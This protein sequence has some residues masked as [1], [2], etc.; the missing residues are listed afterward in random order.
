MSQELMITMAVVMIAAMVQSMTGFG[1]GLIV[2]GL[3]SL[4]CPIKSA[5]VLNVLPALMI[6]GLLIWRLRHHLRWE[7]L[8]P[9]AIA[10][11][12]M[13]PLGVLL[14]VHLNARV[15]N[16]LLAAVLLATLL[17]PLLSKGKHHPWHACW[18]GVPLGLFSGLLAGAFG[19]GGPPLV[20]YVQSHDYDRYRHV[21]SLQVLLGVAGLMRV[22][23]ML[24]QGSLTREQWAVNGMTCLIVLPGLW[25]GLKL[26]K[27][28]PQK[29][30]RTLVLVM[31]GV[32]MMHAAWR[33][34]G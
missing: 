17:Q 1:F 6:N 24:W 13:T 16:G 22:A 23:S 7:G 3:L 25:I 21:V 14:I 19:T 29:W 11:V 8:R 9:I 18:L 33:A 2:V 10:A 28:L 15:M 4:A 27:H 32:M 31:L 34:V 20:A 26:L 12:C 30:L 5:A